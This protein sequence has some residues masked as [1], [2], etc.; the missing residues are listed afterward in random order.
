MRASDRIELKWAAPRAGDRRALPVT[1]EMRT[2]IVV[3]I[4]GHFNVVLSSGT[5]ALR[6]PGDYAIWGHGID[7]SWEALSDSTILTVRWPS[8]AIA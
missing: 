1:H 4:D 7:H 2:T 5:V 3:L 8:T 6:E